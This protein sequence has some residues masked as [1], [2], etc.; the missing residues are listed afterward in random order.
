MGT[1]SQMVPPSPST[2]QDSWPQK[3]SSSQTSSRKVMKLSVYTRC[4]MPQSTIAT[5]ISEEIST[6]TSSSPVDQLFTKDSQTDLRKSLMPWPHNKTWSRSSPQL[7]DTTPSGPVH[8]P[9]APS[10]LSNP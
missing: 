4:A 5:W 6:K 9:F 1:N 7:T 8:Q 10:P 2:P 3:H